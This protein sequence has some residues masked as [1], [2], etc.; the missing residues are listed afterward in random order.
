MYQNRHLANKTIEHQLQDVGA[1]G[2][3]KRDVETFY[4]TKHFMIIAEVPK[5]IETRIEW[6]KI[7]KE[8]NELNLKY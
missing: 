7:N 1:F 2:Y 4:L 8:V 3:N 5:D 6:I